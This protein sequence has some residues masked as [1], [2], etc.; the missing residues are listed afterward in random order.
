MRNVQKNVKETPFS[1]HSFPIALTYINWE[2][3]AIVGVELIRNVGIALVCIFACTLMTLGSWRGSIFVMM[4]VLLTCIDVSGFMHW[5]GLTIDITSMNII[6]I[7]VG[8]CVDFCAHIVHGFLTGHGTKAERVVYIM[9]NIAPAV[10]NGG[11]SSLLALS[12]LA[13]SK[14]HIFVSFF[15]IFFMICVFGLFHGLILLPVVLCLVGPI[16]EK[17]ITKS[18]SK[19]PGSDITGERK[20]SA[21]EKPFLNGR[22]LKTDTSIFAAKPLFIKRHSRAHSKDFGLSSITTANGLP[23]GLSR[24]QS[25]SVSLNPGPVETVKYP[26][27]A[28]GISTEMKSRDAA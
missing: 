18:P 27:Q 14:S 12:L 6:I 2:T 26:P 23:K 20:T 11:F 10:M 8:L 21:S 25:W 16:D 9:E 28:N 5:W 7:S 24:A 3:D 13:G 4:C 19:E 17:E 22:P 1:N 15:K